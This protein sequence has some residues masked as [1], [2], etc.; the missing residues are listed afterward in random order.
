MRWGGIS[1]DKM[2]VI[3]LLSLLF[4]GVTLLH[5]RAVAVSSIPCHDKRPGE[6]CGGEVAARVPRRASTSRRAQGTS[7][8]TGDNARRQGRVPPE[9][10]H[11]HPAKRSSSRHST[12]TSK[13]NPRETIKRATT[14]LDLSSLYGRTRD[15]ALKLRTFRKGKLKTQE[16]NA[17]RTKRGVLTPSLYL[18]YNTMGIPMRP[19]PGQLSDQEEDN[20]NFLPSILSVAP[21]PTPPAPLTSPSSL[22]GSAPATT[23]SPPPPPSSTSSA[24]AFPNTVLFFFC[25]LHQ[26]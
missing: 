3:H 2:R 22:S 17:H 18:P 20:F 6:P 1:P 4:L 15:V 25:S 12:G 19:Q 9:H 23:K 16:V 24:T 21:T 5:G 11:G 10:S 13:E 14:W 8:S 26:Y 7:T